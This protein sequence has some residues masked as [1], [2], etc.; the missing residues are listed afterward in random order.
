MTPEG[1]RS[2]VPHGLAQ[3]L[4]VSHVA[5][6]SAPAPHPLPRPGSRPSSGTLRVHPIRRHRGCER[7]GRWSLSRDA[8]HKTTT[9]FVSTAPAPALDGAPGYARTCRTVQDRYAGDVGDFMKLG[10]LRALTSWSRDRRGGVAR[11]YRASW[12]E[13]DQCSRMK[14]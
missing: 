12:S 2:R 13:T 6:R 9:G 4:D 7:A 5:G 1:R 11:H 10:L 14:K 8:R 3:V